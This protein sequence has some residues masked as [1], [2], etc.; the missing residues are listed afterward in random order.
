[1]PRRVIA[2]HFVC[3]DDLNVTDHGNGTF[4][5]G[6]WRVAESAAQ[7]VERVALHASKSERSYR[8]GRVLRRESVLHEDQPHWQFLIR[9][10]EQRVDWSGGGAGEKGYVWSG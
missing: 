5:T 9:V 4:T 1:M 10:D 7:S 2:M 6:V 3:R 8:Q